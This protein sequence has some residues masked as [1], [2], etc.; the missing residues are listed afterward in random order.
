[1]DHQGR[2][3]IITDFVAYRRPLWCHSSWKILFNNSHRI[4]QFTFPFELWN[5]FK[6][7]HKLFYQ[8]KDYWTPSPTAQAVFCAVS[9]LS[10]SLA[11]PL[12]LNNFYWFCWRSLSPEHKMTRMGSTLQKLRKRCYFEPISQFFNNKQNTRFEIVIKFAPI[13]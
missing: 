11:S 10:P 1:M 9:I 6:Y 3:S 5:C 4:I 7:F 12:S 13:I 2:L 8:I